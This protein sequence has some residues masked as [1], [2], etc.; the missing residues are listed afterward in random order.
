MA[1]ESDSLVRCR[2]RKDS[3]RDPIIPGD[4]VAT[5]LWSPGTP[6]EVVIVGIPEFGGD[7]DSDRLKLEQLVRRVGGTVEDAV[8]PS[9]TVLIDAGFPKATGVAADGQG[10][11]KQLTPKQREQRTLQ[12][13]EAKRL[14]IKVVALEPFL[15]MLGLRTESV[16]ENRLPV[17]AAAR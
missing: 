4:V 6:L 15:A 16:R 2:V 10:P 14:G 17:P 3:T 7:A 13:E 1:I 12:L 8:T 9:T 11:R 5:T